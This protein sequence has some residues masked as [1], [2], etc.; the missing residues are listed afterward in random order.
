MAGGKNG[1]RQRHRYDALMKKIAIAASVGT[2]LA[3]MGLVAPAAAWA[4]APAA[5]VFVAVKTPEAIDAEWRAH[6]CALLPQP[7]DAR[8]LK[9][10]RPRGGG[11]ADDY[12]VLSEKPLAMAWLK[13]NPA[14]N[15]WQLERLHDFSSYAAALQRERKSDDPEANFSLAAALYPLSEGRWAVAVTLQESESYSG[16]GASYVTADFVPLDTPPGKP[17]KAVYSDIPY[18]CSQSI[19][20][21]FSEK[22]YETSKHC[23]DESRGSLR[24]A[25]DEPSKAG[26]PYVWRYTWLQSV[27]PAN[28]GPASNK[29]TSVSFTN[30]S[31]KAVDF[32]GGG[33]QR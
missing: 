19:R 23:H 10:H 17:I 7:C 33:L 22:E 32:C 9:L 12:V 30:D 29:R 16:G 24:I 8:A 11:A 4:A 15:A 1:E 26:A 31:P 3:I 6:L 28:T 21:C 20:A 2:A 14:T 13:R 18:W 5:Q 25:Y 27:W